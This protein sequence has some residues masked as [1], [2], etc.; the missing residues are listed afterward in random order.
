MDKHQK[1]VDR[2]FKKK[3]WP[4]WSPHE[5]FTRLIEEAGELARLLNHLYGPKK[6]KASELE[7]NLEEELG[8]ILYTLICLGN[9]L[10]INLDKAIAKS[11]KKVASRDKNRYPAS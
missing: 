1:A 3:K 8:D 9:G 10:N 7:Q 5:Q 2:W 6:K 11:M 4:Y